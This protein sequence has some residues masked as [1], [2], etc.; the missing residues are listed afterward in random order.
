[1]IEREELAETLCED[2]Q[3][4]GS[5]REGAGGNPRR[6]RGDLCRAHQGAERLWTEFE[7]NL[8][9][10]IDEILEDAEEDEAA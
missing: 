6:P 9:L 2:F 5:D 1:M 3:R 8:D 4:H 7:D 10:R